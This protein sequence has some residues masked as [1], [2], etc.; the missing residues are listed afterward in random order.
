MTAMPQPSSSIVL[1]P[2]EFRSDNVEAIP[3][4]SI[5]S[6]VTLN[7]KGKWCITSHY[8]DSQGGATITLPLQLQ[9]PSK[10]EMIAFISNKNSGGGCCIKP[11]PTNYNEYLQMNHISQPNTDTKDDETETT[12]I[13]LKNNDDEVGI[14]AKVTLTFGTGHAM[15][16]KVETVNILSTYI[17]GSTNS[18]LFHTHIVVRVSHVEDHNISSNA[19]DDDNN[20]RKHAMDGDN[21]DAATIIDP[22]EASKI[23]LNLEIMATYFYSRSTAKNIATSNL[24]YESAL[25]SLSSTNYYHPDMLS[26][27]SI[28]PIQMKKLVPVP[29]VLNVSLVHTLQISSLRTIS[30]PTIMGQTFI[31]FTLTHAN[32]HADPIQITNVA[33]H[34]HKNTSVRWGFVT[35]AA[36]EQPSLSQSNRPNSLITEDWKT[37]IIHPHESQSILLLV[38]EQL[39][40]TLPLRNNIVGTKNVAGGDVIVADVTCFSGTCSLTITTSTMAI[41]ATTTAVATEAVYTTKVTYMAT[42]TTIT[43]SSSG[44]AMDAHALRISMSI[45]PSLSTN[46]D[47]SF[48]NQYNNT[49]PLGQHFVVNIDVE[50]LGPSITNPQPFKL[51]VSDSKKPTEKDAIPFQHRPISHPARNDKG[52][53]DDDDVL[54]IDSDVE[55]F[56]G[57]RAHT[58]RGQL[59]MIPLRTGTIAIPNFYLMDGSGNMYYCDHKFQAI[60]Q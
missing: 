7:S 25:Q 48:P 41:D 4:G 16:S 26:S 20:Q 9:F 24:N 55:L 34:L 31:A 44:S 50:N 17:D 1:K 8:F 49:V 18:V 14:E 58:K 33:L 36:K 60:V 29:L 19:D 40:P 6:V 56:H 13:P 45:E 54:M 47:N 11:K 22:I 3:F 32:A 15:T 10:E 53:D 57:G 46:K 2:L 12:N 28:A 21:Y 43:A 52:D 35:A 23:K 59:R 37:M 27:V 39:P 5:G 42:P 30:H 38:E 51:I